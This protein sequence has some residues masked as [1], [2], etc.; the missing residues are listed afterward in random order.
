MY[1]NAGPRCYNEKQDGMEKTEPDIIKKLLFLYLAGDLNETDRKKLEEWRKS[2]PGHEALFRRITSEGFLS[3]SRKKCL[4]SPEE[5]EREWEKI[6]RRTFRSGKTPWRG[7][8]R[9]AAIA[10]LTLGCGLFLLR[11]K[12]S[13]HPSPVQT[14]EIQK[15][16]ETGP[17]LTLSDGSRVAL[18]GTKTEIRQGEHTSV[19]HSGDTLHY[20]EKETRETTVHYNTLTIPQGSNYH[21]MLSDGTVVYLNT[22][23]SLRYPVSFTGDIREVE[24]SGE[25]YFQVKKDPSR[26]F[27]VKANGIGI[28][29][30]G[31]SFNVRAYRDEQE[32]STTLVEGAVRVATPQ[33]EVILS[34]SQQAVCYTECKDI[35]VQTVNTDL[36]TS[37]M[38]GRF[39]FDNTCLDDILIRLRKWYG[40]EIFYENQE[41][42]ELPFSLNIT[43][44]DNFNKL[45]NA[46]E[47]TRRVK[48]SVKDKTVIV[49]HYR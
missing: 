19:L 1:T 21:L 20:T 13:V 2:S 23:S 40:I 6:R 26:P 22:A 5:S 3:G 46:L 28:R 30:L 18:S 8:M 35:K 45:L 14:A 12:T 49:R 32:I 34:P 17:V 48:F 44:Y 38:S 4:L 33:S 24:L 11:Q 7:L 10:L 29:V 42:K 9:Y 27:I 41:L 16:E 43:R 31:T 37:W 47:R 15:T 36:Y 25:A 39:V